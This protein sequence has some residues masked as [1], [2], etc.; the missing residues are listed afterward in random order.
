MINFKNF[1]SKNIILI[2]FA[3]YFFYIFGIFIFS[4]HINSANFKDGYILGGDSE[5][6]IEGAY[7]IL[8]LEYPTGKK[9]SYLGYI[10]FISFFLFLKL[11]L[12]YIAISQIFLTV[13]SALCIFRISKK[14]SSEFGGLFSLSLYLFYFPLQIRNFY[15][16]TETLFICSVIFIIYFLI[17]FKK[18]Y[19]SLIIFL[20]IFTILI[21]PHGII[22][23]PSLFFSGFIWLYLNNKKKYLY[24]LI[25]L[26]II[27]TYPILYLLNFYLENM[28]I[29]ENIVN[30]GIIYGYENKDNFLDYNKPIDNQNNLI[31]FINFI[32]NNIKLFIISF[33]KKIYFFLFR[34]RPYYSEVH[35]YYLIAFN[36]I[37]LPL[38]I[39][40]FFKIILKKTF[41]IYFMYF[42]LF[43]FILSISL[44]F[45]DWSGR[46]SLYTMPI[47]FI[48]SGIGVSSLEKFIVKKS[49]KND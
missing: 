12:S 22:L 7:Q 14:F 43:F 37:Y 24:L 29:I 36:I 27:L 5:R 40:G 46:F 23:I 49:I 33:F 1:E 13:L 21:R 4:E 32:L 30:M 35:N 3:V 38:A 28:K 41:G 15:I 19:L 9:S 17:F 42:F 45:V 2:I 16:L 20:I 31:F 34:L 39:Y 47:F 48:F 10:I 26:F 11:N 8:N 6:L 25:F 44:S 18:K